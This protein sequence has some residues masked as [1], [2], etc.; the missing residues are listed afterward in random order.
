MINIAIIFCSIFALPTNGLSPQCLNSRRQALGWIAGGVSAAF[1]AQPA[2]ADEG[3][4]N[5]GNFLQTGM[6]SQPMGVSGQAGKSRPE[7]GVVLRDGSDILRD[8]K[9]GNVLAEIV[10]ASPN[11]KSS[12]LASFSSPWALGK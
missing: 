4:V 10:V 5:V 1:V 3:G 7:T 11:G 2:G 6:V 12:V 8:P 9:T